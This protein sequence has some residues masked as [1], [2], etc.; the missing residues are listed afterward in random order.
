MRCLSKGQA[1]G[2]KDGVVLARAALNAA[3]SPWAPRQMLLGVTVALSGRNV[4]LP[5]SNLLRSWTKEA[6]M[7]LGFSLPLHGSAACPTM[8]LL[9]WYIRE[10]SIRM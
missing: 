1:F 8:V 3:G 9:H 2:G 7:R 5:Q 6:V 10:P 4:S